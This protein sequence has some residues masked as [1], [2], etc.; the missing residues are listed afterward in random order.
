LPVSTVPLR[1]VWTHP[2]GRLLAVDVEP[3]VLLVGKGP[4]PPPALGSDVP[5]E[6]AKELRPIDWHSAN[7]IVGAEAMKDFT[8]QLVESAWTS[9]SRVALI[10][11]N[12]PDKW[13]ARHTFR[14]QAAERGTVRGIIDRA[15][16][17]NPLERIGLGEPIARE[18]QAELRRGPKFQSLEEIGKRVKYTS[19]P[20]VKAQI[21]DQVYHELTQPGVGAMFFARTPQGTKF[22]G[23][24]GSPV[25]VKPKDDADD[26]D[27]GFRPAQPRRYR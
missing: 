10:Y 2:E 8:R 18:L 23:T 5:E 11:A 27:E 6:V 14:E 20:Y 12:N 17:L 26:E 16:P 15:S 22:H 24:T 13:P 4:T 7:R 1:V 25:A 9:I 21:I 3:M 19:M